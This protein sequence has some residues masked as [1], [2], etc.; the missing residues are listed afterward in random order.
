MKIAVF[1]G[2]F[3]PPHTG[4]L[5]I[6]NAALKSLDIDLLIIVPAWRNPFKERFGAPPAL[7]LRWLKKIFAHRKDVVVSDFEVRRGR[8]TYTIETIDYLRRRYRPKKIYLIIGEDNL[9]G[10]KRWHRYRRLAHLVEFVVAR[11][12]GRK[13]LRYKSLDIDVPVSSTELRTHPK[14][15]YLPK[16]VAGE[17][18]RFYRRGAPAKTPRSGTS[19]GR[20][21]S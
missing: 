15:R 1:G 21:R 14:R 10:L 19:C 7:R 2:S 11:R 9:A 4:H 16:K 17:I 12:G 18:I 8:P 3:D 20:R 6:A 13:K 5:A